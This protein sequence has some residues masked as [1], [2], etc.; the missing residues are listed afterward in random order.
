VCPWG[1]PQHFYCIET[2]GREE[3]NSLKTISGALFLEER[4]RE[5]ASEREREREKNAPERPARFV[6]LRPEGEDFFIPRK[7]LRMT[8]I[9]LGGNKVERAS[10]LIHK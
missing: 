5:R 2:S 6:I 4:E 10:F 7:F 1:R 9:I 8:R 3:A